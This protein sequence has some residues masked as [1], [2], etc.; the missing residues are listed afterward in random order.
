MFHNLSIN[1]RAFMIE[2]I[3]GDC[4]IDA[5]TRQEARLLRAASAEQ[6]TV[7]DQIRF[8]QENGQCIV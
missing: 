6:A 2:A 3:R 1:E 7:T 5:R 4:R 8:G